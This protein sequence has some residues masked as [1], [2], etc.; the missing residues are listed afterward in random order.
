MAGAAPT[1]L[2]PRDPQIDKCA[3][4]ARRPPPVPHLSIWSLGVGPVGVA[5]A[6]VCVWFVVDLWSVLWLVCGRPGGFQLVCFQLLL[7]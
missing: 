7:I 6:M 3:P 4:V 1:G 5:L 2:T